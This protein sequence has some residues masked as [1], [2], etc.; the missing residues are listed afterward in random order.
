MWEEHNTYFLSLVPQTTP[1]WFGLRK[2]AFTSSN[3]YNLLYTTPYDDRCQREKVM[4]ILGLAK[5]QFSQTSLINMKKG[6]IGEPQVRD[7]LSKRFGKNIREVG[8]AIW[9]NDILIRGSVD[10]LID[11][12]TGL[13]IKCP[14]KMY[15]CLENRKEGDIYYSH[16]YRSH[17]YQMLQNA[18]IMN[19]KYVVYAVYSIEDKKLYIEKVKCDHSIYLNEIYPEIVKLKED[20]VKDICEEFNVSLNTQ[21][22]GLL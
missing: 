20:I 14:P 13:E 12:E 3:I 2:G 4:E 16:I 6:C 22:K 17:F 11:D 1:I 19:L 18:V 21:I 10:G 8:L 15:K 5:K 9:K 7:Y